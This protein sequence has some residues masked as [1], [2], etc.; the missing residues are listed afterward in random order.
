MKQWELRGF[1]DDPSPQVPDERDAIVHKSQA[2]PQR[3]SPIRTG[4]RAPEP[5]LDEPQIVVDRFPMVF[6]T[7]D[8]ELTFTSSPAPG[9]LHLGLPADRFDDQSLLDLFE[10]DEV[11]IEVVEAHLRALRGRTT[12]VRIKGRGRRF[13]CWISPLQGPHGRLIGTICVGLDEAAM[14]SEQEDADRLTL[15]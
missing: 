15:V 12:T 9:V 11:G 5:R 4:S 13:H 2:T 8:A 10:S 6:W 1:S 3:T 14:A 7:T